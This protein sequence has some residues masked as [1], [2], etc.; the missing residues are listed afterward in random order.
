MSN[1]LKPAQAQ[2]FCPVRSQDHTAKLPFEMLERIFALLPD[3]IPSFSPFLAQW[4]P[5]GSF[6]LAEW[7]NEGQSTS[8][9]MHVIR[10]AFKPP[11]PRGDCSSS[12]STS[13]LPVAAVCRRWRAIALAQYDR[14]VPIPLSSGRL[15]VDATL[16]G[17]APLRT[18]LYVDEIRHRRESTAWNI[19]RSLLLDPS[20]RLRRLH[21]SLAGPT[22]SD[23]HAHA[24]EDHRA[25]LGEC[26]AT[27]IQELCVVGADPTYRLFGSVILRLSGTP[28]K[29]I[30]PPSS[31]ATLERVMLRSC[32]LRDYSALCGCRQLT[33]LAL[34][35]CE[36]LWPTTESMFST[37]SSLLYLRDLYIA[38]KT[39]PRDLA[40]ERRPE[41]TDMASLDRL[42]LSGS[43]DQIVPFLST[44]ILRPS[45]TLLLSCH[46][47]P[48]A[49]AGRPV[50]S[51]A[52][53]LAIVLKKHF[54]PAK[55][56]R[57]IFSR[58]AMDLS[59]TEQSIVCAEPTSTDVLCLE[60]AFALSVRR[61]W[62]AV[63][64]AG[65]GAA[66]DAFAAVFA[67]LPTERGTG[68]GA[69]QV[70]VG[71]S[72]CPGLRVH[73]VDAHLKRGLRWWP[74]VTSLPS[75]RTLVLS[76]QTALPLARQLA[77]TGA[78][79][80]PCLS[81]LKVDVSDVKDGNL[82]EIEDALLTRIR[83]PAHARK[84]SLAFTP[85]ASIG[86]PKTYT[87]LFASVARRHFP[88]APPPPTSEARPA[89]LGPVAAAGMLYVYAFV[90]LVFFC[91]A[92]YS[93][94]GVSFAA[95]IPVSSSISHLNALTPAARLAKLSMIQP[96]PAAFE[97]FFSRNAGFDMDGVAACLWA[98]ADDMQW[99]V[100]WAAAWDGPLSIVVSTTSL[101]RHKLRAFVDR[102]GTNA[103]K[104]ALHVLQLR[105]GPQDMPAADSQ[106]NL[107]L[108][109]DAPT[110]LT[111]AAARAFPYAPLAP[112]L[113]PRDH[114]VWCTERF[115]ARAADA[116][117][118]DWA[119][120]VW[121]LHLNG[122]HVRVADVPV[123]HA[124]ADVLTTRTGPAAELDALIHRR[125]SVR[126]RAE[127]C[128]L[129]LKRREL[130]AAAGHEGPG[131]IARTRW[132]EA[133]CRPWLA[134]GP[135]GRP[136]RGK[137]AS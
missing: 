81:E 131:D 66:E 130:L 74:F 79:C 50:E 32:V 35:S 115:F 107:V 53:A 86:E 116:R 128:V 104:L 18:S 109:T 125:M 62:L 110:V 1:E 60:T 136:P 100:A 80:F 49:W 67:A 69:A 77:V 106:A 133:E 33:F 123:S 95:Q 39:W 121:Q 57:E 20:S 21:I 105:I 63:R 56:A 42:R 119:E 41:A 61:D 75:L 64:E 120:C 129:A 112:L 87:T 3:V 51:D 137:I 26:N 29:I 90:S 24:E 132:V 126:F 84:S 11:K 94:L 98:N 28:R 82:V 4:V 23:Q 102:Q 6:T 88:Y 96:P 134:E 12:L 5:S 108:S 68:S 17:F 44:I 36:N 47:I 13:W 91:T 7:V 83:P 72:S 10:E 124:A 9:A 76:S 40:A 89:S 34:D 30:L 122:L 58:I 111:P 22:C 99:L 127:T 93:V 92:A 43:I 27:G 45:T 97:P 37:L 103:S 113:I 85:F 38:G 14:C 73:D 2:G 65:P 15:A 101:E 16:N 117:A 114:D 70:S 135:K 118:A 25:L 52:A 46:V 31:I 59:E 78:E 54:A 71:I 48:W 19:A 8:N 55:A